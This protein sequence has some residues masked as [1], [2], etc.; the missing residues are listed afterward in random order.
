MNPSP[1][2]IIELNIKHYRT[3]LKSETD[4]LKRKTITALLAEEEAKFYNLL[5]NDDHSDD[6][7]A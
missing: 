1:R 7:H 2:M 5:V 3:L 4:A 6:R